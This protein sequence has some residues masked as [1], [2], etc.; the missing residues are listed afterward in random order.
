MV[1]SI[2]LHR[3]GEGR[4]HWHRRRRR[5]E[6]DL[7]SRTKVEL[8][9]NRAFT[10]KVFISTPE[11]TG[12]AYTQMKLQHRSRAPGPP[13]NSRTSH[14]ESLATAVDKR[15]QRRRARGET[16][17]G[18]HTRQTDAQGSQIEP[19][20]P[21]RAGPTLP[22]HGTRTGRPPRPGAPAA[23]TSCRGAHSLTHSTKIQIAT[24]KALPCIGPLSNVQREPNNR[25]ARSFFCACLTTREGG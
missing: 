20:E 9:L 17:Q 21:N 23:R 18:Q 5:A 24:K 2:Y 16:Y 10:G 12:P 8:V 15:D 1:T 6:H 19:Q 3:N 11:D 7:W 22:K 4:F 14:T 25:N 13:Y